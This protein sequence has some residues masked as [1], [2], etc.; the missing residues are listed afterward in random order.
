MGMNRRTWKRKSRPL[1]SGM[2]CG[3]TFCG[4][5]AGVDQ[6]PSRPLGPE[7]TGPRPGHSL[8][9]RFSGGRF[10]RQDPHPGGYRGG[11]SG[12]RADRLRGGVEHPQR[13]RA[14]RRRRLRAESTKI[15]FLEDTDG[16]DRGDRKKVLLSGRRQWGSHQTINS[17]ARARGDP[18]MGSDGI[19]SR[20]RP[21]GFERGLTAGIYRFRP[22]TPRPTRSSTTGWA[23]PT[24]GHGLRRVGTNVRRRWGGWGF[25]L[26]PGQV[27]AQNRLKP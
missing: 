17:F 20:W 25:R 6:S 26:S 13:L 10:Q 5:E 22:R 14:G 23:R 16:D 21:R 24:P 12:R 18:F 11:R 3:S 7:W 9:A 8:S 19:E 4:R 2:A 27:P 15:T 1:R